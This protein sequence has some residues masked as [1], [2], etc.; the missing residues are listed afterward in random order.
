MFT[1]KYSMEIMTMQQ[2]SLLQIAAGAA[3]RY[4]SILNVFFARF[5]SFWANLSILIMKFLKIAK[6]TEIPGSLIRKTL[7]RLLMRRF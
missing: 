7:S 1:E 4:L 3:K 2:S 6:K 5:H